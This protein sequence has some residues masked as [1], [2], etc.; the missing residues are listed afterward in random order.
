MC[1]IVVKWWI[2]E[3]YQIGWNRTKT[4]PPSSIIW[5][6]VGGETITAKITRSRFSVDFCPA[7]LC[8]CCQNQGPV[9]IYYVALPFTRIE[10]GLAPGKAVKCPNGA[11]AIWRAQVMSNNQSNAGVVVFSR[12]GDLNLGEFGDAIILKT[13]GEVPDDLHFRAGGSCWSGSLSA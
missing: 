5:G 9:V 3:G 1:R 4:K 8:S 7:P 10:G 12:R 13:F 2:A 6:A 11:A